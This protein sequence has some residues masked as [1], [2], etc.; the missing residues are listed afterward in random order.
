MRSI[1]F[2]CAYSVLLCYAVTINIS[3]VS[4]EL[5]E[6]ISR[7]EICKKNMFVFLLDNYYVW[8]PDWLSC[9]FI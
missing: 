8:K 5:I 4:S 7:L 3:P 2:I 9:V 1:S 6:V